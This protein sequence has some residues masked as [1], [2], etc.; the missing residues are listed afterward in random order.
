M[1][2]AFDNIG[3]VSQSLVSRVFI[4]IKCSMDHAGSVAN[5]EHEVKAVCMFVASG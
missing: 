3:N 4:G 1:V 5:G 2:S